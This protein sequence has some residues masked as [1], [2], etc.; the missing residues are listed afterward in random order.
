MENDSAIT[1]AAV[2]VEVVAF[3]YE[4][5][6]PE[7]RTM[8]ES[9][10]QA[11][12]EQIRRTAQAIVEVG[13]MLIDVKE[14]LPHGQF[15]LWLQVEFNWDIRTAQNFMSVATMFKNETS[16]AFAKDLL[17]KISIDQSALYILAAKST[18][19]KIRHEILERAY[20]GEP[21][22]KSKVRQIVNERKAGT[23]RTTTKSKSKRKSD[24]P[25]AIGMWVRVQTLE[26][27]ENWDRCFGQIVAE[28]EFG[29][30]GVKLNETKERCLRVLENPL[31]QGDPAM[32]VFRFYPEELTVVFCPPGQVIV[33]HYPGRTGKEYTQYN[34]CWAIV[35]DVTEQGNLLVNLAGVTT[36]VMKSDIDPIDDLDKSF[37][38]AARQVT[39][40][41]SRTDL[42]PRERDILLSFLRSTNFTEWDLWLLQKIV[43]RRQEQ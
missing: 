36:V 5:V 42:E 7:Y 19:Q 21:F 4:S 17:D 39:Q 10:T 32:A 34:G 23:E 13:S 1:P 33:M 15:T 29:K 30:Y 26:G 18:P 14:R 16:F 40:M 6:E 9:R 2:N 41:L 28:P 43:E 27:N 31:P 25:L 12:K 20:Q 11:I 22:T 38:I 8:I 24:P 37:P 35:E 3:D